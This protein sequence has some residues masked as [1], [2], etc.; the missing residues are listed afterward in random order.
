MFRLWNE[1]RKKTAVVC[2]DLDVAPLLWSARLDTV[3][4]VFFS[5]AMYQARCH[6]FAPFPTCSTPP[7]ARRDHPPA[8]ANKCEKIAQM[9]AN[10]DDGMVNLVS[11]EFTL[12][13]HIVETA[14][15]F[16]A[17]QQPTS[18]WAVLTYR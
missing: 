13:T 1:V 16:T 12:L 6:H 7:S 9:T 5:G 10:D 3:I 18:I 17:E 8:N 2:L 15:F 4:Y 14:L 11:W